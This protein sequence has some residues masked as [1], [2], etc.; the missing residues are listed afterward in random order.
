MSAFTSRREKRRTVEAFEGVLMSLMPY[1]NDE[2][3]KLIKNGMVVM[4]DADVVEEADVEKWNRAADKIYM[5]LI[6]VGQHSEQFHLGE[7]IR[8]DPKEVA[9]IIRDNAV[10]LEDMQ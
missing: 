8:Y 9:D 1:L 2:T 5:L 10:K 3:K 4:R 6:D 7:I